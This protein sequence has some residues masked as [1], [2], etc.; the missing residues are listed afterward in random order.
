MK[1]AELLEEINPLY[2]EDLQSEGHHSIFINEENYKILIVRGLGISNKGLEYVSKGIV[3]NKEKEVF[4][5]DREEENLVKSEAG[6]SKML[7]IISPIY[8]RNQKIIE[9][10][11][12]EVDKLEDSLFERKASR[13]FMDI[14]FDIKKDLSRI[15]RHLIRNHTILNNFYK[16]NLDEENFQEAEF[17]DLLE[18]IQI[19]HHNSNTQLSRLDAL[20]NYYG[21]IKNDKLNRNIFM[22][23]LFSAVFLPLNLIVGFFG[24]N[25]ENLF[26]KDN[27]LGTKYVLAILIGSLTITVFGLP[28]I[29]FIDN[30]ILKIFL[31]RYDI[32]KKISKKLDKLLK[33]E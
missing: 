25:T 27:P 11:V 3:I 19:N 21:S 7:E 33:I 10:Y 15:E 2:I 14:W 1:I 24:I 30:H 16:A 6:Y 8:T 4:Y 20:Y 23:T 26:F 18:Q 9:S 29:R 28:L 12:I 5:Y 17:R 22:L 31:G 13:I 32:Y